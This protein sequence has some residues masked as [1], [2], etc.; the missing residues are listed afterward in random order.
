MKILAEMDVGAPKN[1]KQFACV[2]A[3]T[4]V[5]F[6]MSRQWNMQSEQDNF[7]NNVVRSLDEAIAWF[8]TKGIEIDI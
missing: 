4:D 6:G 8:G 5:L 3:P 1:S 2:V 7:E